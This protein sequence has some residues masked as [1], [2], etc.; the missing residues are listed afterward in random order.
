MFVY[1]HET[2][3]Y[4]GFGFFIANQFTHTDTGMLMRPQRGSG[5]VFIRF[6]KPSE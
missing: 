5:R 6:T 3:G 1:D 4:L 2:S